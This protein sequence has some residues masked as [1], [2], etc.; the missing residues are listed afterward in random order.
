MRSDR[1]LPYLVSAFEPHAHPHLAPAQ[2]TIVASFSLCGFSLQRPPQ[3]FGATGRSVDTC[4]RSTRV[5]RSAAYVNKPHAH[6]AFFVHDRGETMHTEQLLR[7]RETSA[8]V[9]AV[10]CGTMQKRFA[11]SASGLSKTE[12][13]AH[14]SCS[15]SPHS[16]TPQF[17]CVMCASVADKRCAVVSLSTIVARRNRNSAQRNSDYAIRSCPIPSAPSGRGKRARAVRVPATD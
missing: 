7:F 13:R 16:Y 8:T 3:K 10:R 12:S 4:S 17:R 15:S 11:R 1:M 5:N 6:A 14:Y 9:R 2:T